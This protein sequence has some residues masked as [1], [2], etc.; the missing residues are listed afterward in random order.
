MTMTRFVSR[1]WTLRRDR[2]RVYVDHADDPAIIEHRYEVGPGV[3]A[4]RPEVP[5]QVLTTARGMLL[6]VP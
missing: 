3:W 1:K 2:N 4:A 6:R 5:K